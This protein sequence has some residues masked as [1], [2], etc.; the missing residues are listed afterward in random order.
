MNSNYWE[1]RVEE[2]E[3]RVMEKEEKERI[4][5]SFI[6][7]RLLSRGILENGRKEDEQDWWHGQH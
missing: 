4:L 3:S 7:R 2:S 6:L 5:S 1:Y